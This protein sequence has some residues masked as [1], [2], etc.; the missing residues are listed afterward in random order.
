MGIPESK[1]FDEYDITSDHFVFIHE[2][3]VIGSVRL[4]QTENN[5]KLERMAIYQKY[6]KKNFGI[7]AISKIIKNYKN[8]KFEKIILDSIYDVRNFYKKCGF[9]EIGKVF[10]RVGFSHIR[11][12]LPL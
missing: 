2:L 8:K 1:I 12:E 5:I 7:D 4:R 3:D 11:M 9:V 6:R 10:D